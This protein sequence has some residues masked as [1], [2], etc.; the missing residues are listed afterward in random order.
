MSTNEQKMIEMVE[1]GRKASEIFQ[2][3]TQEQVDEVIKNLCIAF[4]KEAATMAKMTVEETGMGDYECKIM[5]NTGCPA[6]AWAQVKGQK[7]MGIIG[8]DKA[9]RLRFVAKPKGVV[10][11]VAP[12]TNPNVTCMFVTA[13]SL[14]GRNA[15]I[16][17][18]HPG[19]KN[20]T[21]YSADLLR[22][23]LEEQ[24]APVDLVQVVREPSK[25]MSQM[26]MKHCDVT[27]ATGGAEMVTAANS[28]GH[29]SFGV[30][31]G[32]IQGILDDDYAA[33]PQF[34]A[35]SIV[36]RVFDN[37][38]VC[39]CT[40][41]M[42]IP[43]GKEQQVV[44]LIPENG[45]V[46]I[47]DEGDIEKIKNTIFKNGKNNPD[48]IGRTAQTIAEMAGVDI[49]ADAKAIVLKVP[50]EGAGTGN[51]LYGEKMNPVMLLITTKSLEEAVDVA[52][53]NLE[54]QGAGHSSQ[55]H[56]DNQ[57]NADYALQE[58]PICRLMV[59]QPG[60]T[61][62]NPGLTNGL[63]PTCS[64]GCGS[65]GNNSLSENL[66]FRHLMNITCATWPFDPEDVP[67][68]MAVFDD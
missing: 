21:V 66:T 19:A 1:K 27:V 68:V 57:D 63:E 13:M 11:N 9:K 36:S 44:D 38:I 31:P 30:G 4:Q 2:T 41:S 25:E 58:L 3:Y 51:E 59:N 62:A 46:L 5:K 10:G 14:K 54:Q 33:V 24:G 6:G 8:E 23:S 49:P 55:M 32:N 52:K 18:P 20:T 26:L 50:A 17:S 34:V 28:S 15:A 16:V 53:K 67:D 22:K 61:T 42:I 56:T 45:G 60:F 64:M 48:T 40:Q 37:G 43:E 65:W 12:T 47:T 29:P 7:S 35:E 39:S